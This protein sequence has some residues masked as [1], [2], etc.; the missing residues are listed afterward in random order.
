MSALMLQ[1]AFEL[2][3]VR[4]DPDRLL[5]L[6][7]LPSQASGPVPARL[8]PTPGQLTTRRRGHGLELDD[9]RVWIPGDDTRHIDRN[10]TARTGV[11]HLR[12][13]RDERQR[14]ALLA[15]DFRPSMLFGTRRA[16]RSVAAAEALAII[17]WRVI[18]E[19][20]R[21]GLL[22]FGTDEPVFV[23]PAQGE[24]A[25]AAA[26]A[27]MARAHGKALECHDDQ[28]PPLDEFMNMAVRCL[29]RGG[30]LVLATALDHTGEGFERIARSLAKRG[31]LQIILVTDAFE[32]APPPGLYP[33]LTRGW[34][35]AQGIIKRTR[36][37]SQDDTRLARLRGLGIH[38]VHL[39]AEVE[40]ENNSSLPDRL[41]VS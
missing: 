26:I 13:F 21:V 33:Y 38:A 30:A 5:R 22:T 28:E 6:R 7:H 17:G 27:G 19:G 20:G 2:P 11:P 29:P 14:T 12:T 10:A 8:A 25:M 39:A 3:G 1:D 15:A 36:E 18:S 16:F 32:R 34:R 35:R 40:P 37:A 23:R 24:R 4:L 41:F 9:I 31:A